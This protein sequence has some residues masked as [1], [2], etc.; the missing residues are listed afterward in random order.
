MANYHVLNYTISELLHGRTVLLDHS[1]ATRMRWA[2]NCATSLKYGCCTAALAVILRDGSYLNICDSKSSPRGSRLGTISCI[3]ITVGPQCRNMGTC[4]LELGTRHTRHETRSHFGNVSLKS[5]NCVTPGQVAS[6]G[7]PS[8]RKILNNS[9]ISCNTCVLLSSS[10]QYE[11]GRKWSAI[12]RAG[13]TTCL[14]CA[15]QSIRCTA[16]AARK[17][18]GSRLGYLG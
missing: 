18:H 7:V 17:M 10:M 1:Q 16:E 15:K 4:H 5:A 13:S 8:T 6:L 2:N 14:G 3:P 12:R 9:S 11:I